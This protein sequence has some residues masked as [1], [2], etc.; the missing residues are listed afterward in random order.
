MIDR[1]LE[2]RIDNLELFRYLGMEMTRVED[3]GKEKW[4]LSGC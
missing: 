3:S 2:S 1:E 4:L